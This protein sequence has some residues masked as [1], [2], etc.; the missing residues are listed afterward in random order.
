MDG[1]RVREKLSRAVDAL[2][3]GTGSIQQRLADAGYHFCVLSLEQDVPEWMQEEYSDVDAEL[4]KIPD[5]DIGS[6]RATV[7]TLSDEEAKS[8]ARRIVAMHGEVCRHDGIEAGLR[9]AQREL[10]RA[11]EF[12]SIN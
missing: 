4:T 9:Q 3:I 1:A 8:L 5:T 6:I 10:D 12:D 2:A 11:P 7:R